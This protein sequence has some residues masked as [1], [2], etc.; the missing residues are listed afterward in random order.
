[1]IPRTLI[2]CAIGIATYLTPMLPSAVAQDSFSSSGSPQ[3]PML[4]GAT[5]GTIGPVGGYDLEFD[6]TE[7]DPAYADARFTKL[8]WT[9]RTFEVRDPDADELT[10][11]FDEFMD[12]RPPAFSDLHSGADDDAFA[13]RKTSKHIWSWEDDWHSMKMLRSSGAGS[14][15]TLE[16]LDQ[17][18]Y[19]R[20]SRNVQTHRWNWRSVSPNV[21]TIKIVFYTKPSKADV[22]KAL[23]ELQMTDCTAVVVSPTFCTSDGEPTLK[24]VLKDI[25]H[26]DTLY[27]PLKLLYRV[28]IGSTAGRPAVSQ[29][30][31]QIKI[32]Q[33]STKPAAYKCLYKLAQ[34]LTDDPVESGI[35]RGA[36][37]CADGNWDRA[38][39]CFEGV[40]DLAR[41]NP[42]I[43]ERI[44]HIYRNVEPPPPP[45]VLSEGGGFTSMP[46]SKDKN[47]DLEICVWL[48][49]IIQNTLDW[50]KFLKA[51]HERDNIE[52][53]YTA[54]NEADNQKLSNL[55]WDA[56]RMPLKVYFHGSDKQ[57]YNPALME[58]FRKCVEYWSTAS[59]TKID[60]VLV[61][62]KDEPDITLEWVQR[63]DNLYN[64]DFKDRTHVPRMKPFGT[65][66]GQTWVEKC[67]DNKKL[68]DHARI[69]IFDDCDMI[70]QRLLSV[71]LHE[72]GHAFGIRKHLDSSPNNV[73]Y[74]AIADI[75]EVQ[76][77]KLTAAD[78]ETMHKLY[79]AEPLCHGAIER[80]V[81]LPALCD[82]VSFTPAPPIK[83]AKAADKQTGSADT[84]GEKH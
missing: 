24:E 52:G 36:E 49:R 73:M 14:E 33:R 16:E 79:A 48:T 4:Q 55:H 29:N 47:R 40:N 18:V 46:V 11:G 56:E 59:G 53:P 22:D 63:R 43:A 25:E 78:S 5:N 45:L 42:D 69:E 80:F 37:A 54:Q 28:Q 77:T 9:D 39:F 66:L 32:Y 81:A 71:L 30:L 20:L 65:R 61:G 83:I 13:N 75:E 31:P 1:M 27:Q 64:V 68:I 10:C 2:L 41:N 62:A 19:N 15:G 50:D 76:K 21:K 72:T 70:D 3:A 38:W 7:N 57:G 67:A 34:T 74:Y 82:R 12:A 26:V 23:S 60:Y 44:V 51:L 6:T 17:W 35:F 58:H 84:A 8:G